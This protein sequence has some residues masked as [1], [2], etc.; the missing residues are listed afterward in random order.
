MAIRNYDFNKETLLKN[1]IL[2][3]LSNYLR[4]PEISPDEEKYY[5]H[6]VNDPEVVTAK[7]KAKEQRNQ[8]NDEKRKQQEIYNNEYNHLYRRICN[9]TSSTNIL[10]E[11]NNIKYEVEQSDMLTPLDKEILLKELKNNI[12]KSMDT[13]I[14]SIEQWA[15]SYENRIRFCRTIA[16]VERLSNQYNIDIK[17]YTDDVAIKEFTK[18]QKK[19]IKLLLAYKSRRSQMLADVAIT[20]LMKKE[21]PRHIDKLRNIE[22]RYKEHIEVLNEKINFYIENNISKELLNDDRTTNLAIVISEIKQKIEDKF[23][24]EY[25]SKLRNMAKMYNDVNF[26]KDGLCLFRVQNLPS[27]MKCNQKLT[28]VV[29]NIIEERKKEIIES[30]TTDITVIHFSDLKLIFTTLQNGIQIKSFKITIQ[31]ADFYYAID[32]QFKIRYDYS[33]IAGTTNIQLHKNRTF[34][35][36]NSKD[37]Y[38]LLVDSYNTKIN[39]GL[40][41]I[42]IDWK[43]ITFMKNSIRII[44]PQTHQIITQRA[45]CNDT[46]NRIKNYISATLPN[47]KAKLGIDGKYALVEPIKLDIAIKR[48]QRNDDAPE[49]FAQAKQNYDRWDRRPT[50]ENAIAFANLSINQD[51]LLRQLHARKQKYIETLIKKQSSSYKLIPAKESLA[52]TNSK[53]EEY[54]FIFTI[55]N[56]LSRFVYIVYENLNIAR[57]SIVCK[58]EKEYYSDCLQALYNHMSDEQRINKRQEMQWHPRK[59]CRGMVSLKSVN[60][61]ESIYEWSKNLY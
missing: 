30:L 59:L 18:K 3:H 22:D 50:F 51:Y 61:I 33:N 43:D 40:D 52:H 29:D 8:L 6:I 37:M 47:I 45:I 1:K 35:F 55:D 7:R 15:Q 31:G 9:V 2:K 58:V 56:S 36:V 26:L 28:K 42:T 23:I 53:D 14:K 13:L 48:I 12:Q 32:K 16:E 60:H 44:I 25:A 11:Y 54:A 17:Q 5:V 24:S 41:I 46:Y 49:L 38:M 19:Q 10:N 27:S 4:E 34:S 21:I 39:Q 20:K 57:A